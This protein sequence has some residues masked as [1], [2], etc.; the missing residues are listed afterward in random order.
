M[1]GKGLF[2]G[3][4]ITPETIMTRSRGT[5]ISKAQSAHALAP[6]NASMCSLNDR[7]ALDGNT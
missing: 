7:Y 6:G 2:A 5:K 4:D 1:A 3:Q